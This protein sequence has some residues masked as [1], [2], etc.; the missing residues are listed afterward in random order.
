M[1]LRAVMASGRVLGRVGLDLEV[2][3][4]FPGYHVGR[5]Q[6]AVGRCRFSIIARP[7]RSVQLESRIREI[8]VGCEGYSGPTGILLCGC[9]CNEKVVY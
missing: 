4:R 8:P 7:G 9:G 5:S 6:K 1:W 3:D 2:S